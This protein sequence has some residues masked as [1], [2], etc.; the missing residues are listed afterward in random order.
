[1]RWWAGAGPVKPIDLGVFIET[2]VLLFAYFAYYCNG[3]ETG[4]LRK[5][6]VWQPI[7]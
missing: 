3:V 1:M 2:K 7:F 6:W 4:R 5:V